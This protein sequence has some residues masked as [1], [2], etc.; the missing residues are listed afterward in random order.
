[1]RILVLS[2]FLVLAS[3][4]LGSAAEPPMSTKTYPVADLIAT[5]YAPTTTASTLGV[6]RPAAAPTSAV[7]SAPQI[8]A[9][10]ASVPAPRKLSLAASCRANAD[11]LQS[12]VMHYV[13]PY[14]WD[15]CGGTGKIAFDDKTLS[16]VVTQTADVHRNVAELLESLRNLQDRTT[17][18]VVIEM[19]VIE[20]GEECA[21]RVKSECG[22]GEKKTVFLTNEQVKSLLETF[23]EDR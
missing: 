5:V 22:L 15:D 16:L 14:S 10:S 21:G 9:A 19:R 13:K 8:M 6:Y 1:M 18:Q 20:L 17:Q 11:R 23:Q 4:N 3:V 2:G 7:A 12:V